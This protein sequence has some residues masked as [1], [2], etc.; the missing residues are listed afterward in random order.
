[1]ANA[2]GPVALIGLVVLGIAVLWARQVAYRTR[3]AHHQDALRLILSI[4]GSLLIL[5]GI[6]GVAAHIVSFFIIIVALIMLGVTL[7][8]VMRFRLLERRT[9]LQCISVAAE[10]GIPLDQAVRGYANERTD[11]MGYR[12]AILAEA[13]EAGM[14]LPDALH[15]SKTSLSTDALFAM[16]LGYETG[17]L[18]PA[19]S[20]VAKSNDRLDSVVRSIFEKYLYLGAMILAVTSCCTFFMIKIVP[21]FEKMFLEFGI[22]LPAITQSNIYV[23]NFF[24]QYY[25]LIV[26]VKGILLML[27]LVAGLHY[28]GCLPR[29]FPGLNRLSRPLDGAMVM[30]AL[31]MAVSFQW[32]LNKTIWLLARIYPK[33][34][35]RRRLSQAGRMIDNGVFWCDTL[36]RAGIIDK[37]D[38]LVLTAAQRVGN[39]EWAL[40][41]MANSSSRRLVYRARL[42]LNVAFPIV[43]LLFGLFVAYFVIGFFY[44]LVRLIEGLI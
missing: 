34:G 40:D 14:S 36:F 9:L 27:L 19:V 2:V 35:M 29:D 31:A 26:P 16:R 17:A 43:L 32:P 12:A 15:Y 39:L 30:R 21:V 13:L 8:L 33:R 28:V 11:E 22:E 44:P 23:A 38:W 1:M 25:I 37:S 5:V 42:L 41:E 24:A 4:S 10:K 6:L 18:G 7:M 3:A 20:R